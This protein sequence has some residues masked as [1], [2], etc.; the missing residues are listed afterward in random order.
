M[1]TK[2]NAPVK[3]RA[4]RPALGSAAWLEDWERRYDKAEKALNDAQDARY[5][6][7]REYKAAKSAGW[8]KLHYL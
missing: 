3:T 7:R 8:K 1:K 5:N 2:I 6:L 4:A